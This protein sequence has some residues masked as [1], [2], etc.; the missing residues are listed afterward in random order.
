MRKGGRGEGGA[1]EGWRPAGMKAGRGADE[2]W[3]PAGKGTPLLRCAHIASLRPHCVPPPTSLREKGGCPQ[4]G[5]H[6]AKR[7]SLRSGV[8]FPAGAPPPLIP[9]PACLHPCWGPASPHPCPPR[10]CPPSERG[11]AMVP[12]WSC[13]EMF[14]VEQ[15]LHL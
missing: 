7:A 9:A 14:H 15:N 10:P 1:D 5:L 8:P 2:G 6:F 11:P 3:R 12:P 13:L 4:R